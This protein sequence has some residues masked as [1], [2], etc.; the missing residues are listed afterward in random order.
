[1]A[2]LDEAKLA[3]RITKSQYDSEISRLINAAKEDLKMIGIFVGD[4]IGTVSEPIKQAIITFCRLNFGTPDDYD[5]LK[6]S[7]DEQRAQLKVSE[8]YG[9]SFENP[10]THSEELDDLY[11]YDDFDIDDFEDG[12]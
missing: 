6:R 11:T 1:M 3:M 4:D 12:D 5:R 2:L 10:V 7:Y 8:N 9:H